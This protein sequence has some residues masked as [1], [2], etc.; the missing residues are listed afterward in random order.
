MD[1]TARI[2]EQTKRRCYYWKQWKFYVSTDQITLKGWLDW[3][4][5]LFEIQRNRPRPKKNK[6]FVP[7]DLKEACV[8]ARVWNKDQIQKWLDDHGYTWRVEETVKYQ[9]KV[10]NGEDVELIDGDAAFLQKKGA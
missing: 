1:E 7:I 6:I 8:K 2:P 10:E 4:N 3:C 9:F 5:E